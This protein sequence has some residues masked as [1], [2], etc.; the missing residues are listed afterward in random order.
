MPGLV[1]GRPRHADSA[2]S[3]SAGRRV[4]T[5]S[6]AATP[7]NK[8]LSNAC[9]C[10]RPGDTWAGVTQSSGRAS[11]TRTRTRD[12]TSIAVLGSLQEPESERRA[13]PEMPRRLRVRNEPGG[14]GAID[15]NSLAV[16]T[17]WANAEPS[18]PDVRSRV[19]R[20]CGRR[21]GKETAVLPRVASVT[22]AARQGEAPLV[23][24]G[25]CTGGFS[26][27]HA[28]LSLARPSTLP[29][30]LQAGF[31]PSVRP[32]LNGPTLS[33]PPVPLLES[34]LPAD[35]LWPWE[36]PWSLTQL[37]GNPRQHQFLPLRQRRQVATLV[38]LSF[39]LSNNLIGVRVKPTEKA[40]CSCLPG[41]P[42]LWLKSGQQ[43]VNESV[44]RDSQA[45]S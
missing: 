24:H 6:S 5:L 30:P 36:R 28:P 18:E 42:V 41:E 44:T 1:L 33:F 19:R 27:P 38:S 15:R 21:A 7:V 11:S 22:G 4:L 2:R 32:V 34:I 20:G 9:G 40:L 10:A 35:P 14:W 23:G 25:H 26:V 29:A 13:A 8:H 16:H 43:Y 39:C 17:M 3:R 31:L 12:V 45:D 37:L